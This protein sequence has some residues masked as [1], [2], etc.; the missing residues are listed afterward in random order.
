MAAVG[1]PE[2]LVDVITGYA[3]VDNIHVHFL[4]LFLFFWLHWAF[5]T[6]FAQ[7]G[8][9][10]VSSV[11]KIIFVGSP[12]V[13][14]MVWLSHGWSFHF[15]FL[16]KECHFNIISWPWLS[17]NS[18]YVYLILKEVEGSY[19]FLLKLFTFNFGM[20][21]MYRPCHVLKKHIL[22]SSFLN[23]FSQDI[24]IKFDE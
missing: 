3:F 14:K 23:Q 9:A 15:P 24:E 22:W 16:E 8:E 6:R 5:L 4:G 19:S 12:G 17:I 1:A 13:G 7:T 10:L 20:K 2:N 18:G 21:I 11:D